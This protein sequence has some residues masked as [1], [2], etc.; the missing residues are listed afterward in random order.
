MFIDVNYKKRPQKAKLHLAKPNKQIFS[1]ISEKYA[2]SLSLKLGNINELTFSIPHYVHDED[3]QQRIPNKHVELIREK[4]LIRVTMG[5]FKEWY[6]VDSIEEDADDTDVFIVTA[7]SLGYELKGKRVSGYETESDNA[8]AIAN[9]LLSETIWSIQEID[10]MF[11]GM[12]RSFESG[13]DSNVLDCIIQW[14]E[15]FGGLLVWDTENR[16]ISLKNMSEDGKFRGMTVNYGKFLRTLKRTRTTEEMVTR[17]HVYG[18]ED[19]TIHSVNPTGMGYIEDFSFFMYPFKRD[20]NKN[21]IQS[22]YF[23]SD[24]LCH[25]ILDHKILLEA[26]SPEITQITSEIAEKN[27]TLI[28]EESELDN[29]KAEL[30]TILKLLDTAKA[31]LAKLESEVPKPDTSA[32]E[33]LVAQRISE[34]DAKQLEINQQNLI[35]SNLKSQIGNLTNQLNT[36]QDEISQQASFTPQLLDELNPYIIES[37]WRD[38]RYID[39]NELYEDAIKKFT[40]LRQP[41]VVI[42]VD[43]D[44]LMNIVEEQYYW[45]KL[46]LG[47]LIKV[48]YPQMN[49]EYM[50]KIIEIN[51]D[52]ENNEASLVIANTTDLLSETEKLVQLLYGSQT[53]STL[54]QNNKYKWNKV[55]AVSEQIS[56]LL[57]SEWDANKNKIIAGVNNSVEVGNRGIIISNPDIPNEMVIMQA[58]IIALTKDG[59]E[60]WKTAIKPDGIVAERLIGQ[61]I[62]GQELLI[63]NGAGSFTLDNNGAV[64]DVS[65][66]IIRSK[67][68]GGN[69]VDRWQDNADFVD[70]Y[71]DDN[72]IT[73]YEKKMLKIKWTEIN[74]RYLANNTKILNYYGSESENLLFVQNFHNRHQELYD[75]LFVTVH[76]DAP[77]LSDENMAFTTR[78]E[79]TVFNAKFR[80]YDS[81]VVEVEK[82]LAIKANTMAQQAIQDAKDAHDLVN[83]VMD[84]VVYKIEIH[85]SN[86]LIFKNGQINTV[87]TAKIYRGKDDITSTLTNSQFIWKKKD[88]DGNL[89]TAW[90]SAHVGIGKQVTIDRNDIY[91]KATFECS[92]DIPE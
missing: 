37:T 4:M 3:T 17:M 76:G 47:E 42:E 66:F 16:K 80:N 23:M 2:D 74:D 6:I 48:K 85:S 79:S 90:N 5:A 24:A 38:D 43:I 50:A 68:G 46:V 45:D 9:N 13:D 11:D 69:L 10:A 87:L 82:Q 89:D 65:A 33:A 81:A 32:E 92:I 62:A 83:E 39:V 27:I 7:F 29:L 44:N 34:R 1:H 73:A 53:A 88:K 60:T 15:T 35:V 28:T 19:L 40:E 14:A 67:S 63:T 86:G 91:Q 58:G 8:T 20:A 61:I 57:T 52:L 49:I 18:S 25:A 77:M 54:V 78:I 12:Y 71:K 55:N 21:V 72:L 64:F 30:E 56:Q 36:L 51:Y 84:D 26:N 22:S 41:K 31:V 59:G 75:Y 70:E